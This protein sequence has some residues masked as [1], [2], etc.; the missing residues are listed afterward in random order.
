MMLIRKY[1]TDDLNEIIKLFYDTV[2]TINAKDYCK[3]Q[4]DAWASKN[5]DYKVWNETLSENYSLLAIIDNNIVGFGDIS[6]IG[7]LDHLYIHKEFQNKGIATLICNELEKHINTLKIKYI[8]SC[9]SITAKPFFEKRKFY[10]LR[11]QYIKRN[12]IIIENFVMK[13]TLLLK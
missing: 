8:T 6:S 2:H 12:N 9:V 4:L 11:K 3:E 13:K 1:T 10:V 5:I 7:Y